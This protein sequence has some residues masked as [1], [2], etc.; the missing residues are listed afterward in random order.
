MALIHAVAAAYRS[1]EQAV[2]DAPSFGSVHLQTDD[3]NGV[4]M[5]VERLVRASSA[6][7]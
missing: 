3:Q 6:R 4:A 5:L 7:A 1:R 2:G